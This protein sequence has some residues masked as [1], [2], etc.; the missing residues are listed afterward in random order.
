MRDIR[1]EQRLL[2]TAQ[3]ELDGITAESQ[4][5]NAKFQYLVSALTVYNDTGNKVFEDVSAYLNPDIPAF[6]IAAAGKYAS[7]LYGVKDDFE[8]TLPENSFLKQYGFVDDNLRLINKEGRLVDG[9]GRLID[10]LGNFVDYDEN[11]ESFKV[12]EKGNPLD[13]NNNLII[14]NSLP[15]LD[16]DGKPIEPPKQDEPEGN[17]EVVDEESDDDSSP[18][19]TDSE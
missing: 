4:A 9:K 17:E 16:E 8:E 6:T 3:T 5:E 1:G 18:A 13:E 12:D 19:Q 15:F 10:T 2:L 11:G 7:I 14:H